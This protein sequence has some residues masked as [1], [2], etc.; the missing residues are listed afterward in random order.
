MYRASND[1]IGR[2]GPLNSRTSHFEAGGKHHYR[3]ERVVSSYNRKD[4]P[5]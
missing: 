1:S 3:S 4:V 5:E 2:S